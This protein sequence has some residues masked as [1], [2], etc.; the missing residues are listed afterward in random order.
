MTVF[1]ASD[2]RRYERELLQA[3]AEAE[4][5]ARAALALEHVNEGVMLV[6]EDGRIDVLNRAAEGLF[7]LV[8]PA[9]IGRPVAG[10]CRTGRRSRS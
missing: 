2:R 1:N 10:F 5:R 8:A 6:A 4:T 9:A 7:G 3:R